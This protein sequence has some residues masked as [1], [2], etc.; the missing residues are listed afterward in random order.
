MVVVA[1]GGLKALEMLEIDPDTCRYQGRSPAFLKLLEHTLK[2][3]TTCSTSLQSM[4]AR[5]RARQL[6]ISFLEHM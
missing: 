6:H 1:T 2:A 5:A 4:R 3:S